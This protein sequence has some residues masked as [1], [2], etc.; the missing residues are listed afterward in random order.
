MQAEVTA[1]EARRGGIANSPQDS[2]PQGSKL[3]GAVAALTLVNVIGIGTGSMD[4][5]AALPSPPTHHRSPEASR[6]S[7]HQTRPGRLSP[8]GRPQLDRTGRKR[9]G[10]ASIYAPMFAGRKMADGTRMRPT[11]NN[12]ASRTLP[13]GTTAKVTNLETG[14]TAVVTIHDRGPYVAGRIVDL[15]PATARDIGLDRRTGVTRVEVAPIV[16]PM[17]NGNIKLG[18]GFLETSYRIEG[19]QQRR[20]MLK[21]QLA[22]RGSIQS[23]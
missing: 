9:F 16:I 3:I 22:D 7:H 1:N 10:K 21:W 20:G 14:K 11:S 4:G 17:P 2:E 8:E 23:R 12:A 13:L 5:A 19:D 18:D 15:S 6:L